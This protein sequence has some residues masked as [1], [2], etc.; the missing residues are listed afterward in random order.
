MNNELGKVLVGMAALLL[1]A[2]QDTKDTP[3]GVG[4]HTLPPSSG[5]PPP[6][7]EGKSRL[8]LRPPPAGAPPRTEPG[9]AS[10]G[11]PGASTGS[12]GT[13]APGNQDRREPQR[14]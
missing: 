13:A 2:G 8:P 7:T 10:R 11:T 9:G 12:S 4:E 1:V 14:Q 6:G 3:S 5:G